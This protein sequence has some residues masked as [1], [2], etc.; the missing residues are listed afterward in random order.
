MNQLNLQSIIPVLKS[1][2]VAFAGVFGSFAKGE[3][4]QE[5]DVDLL[6]RFNQPKSLFGI[7]GLEI[8]LSEILGRKVDLVTERALCPHIKESVLANLQ[9]FYGK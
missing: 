1:N 3:A 7:V 6:V 9:P 2:D 8:E 5:S 4:H